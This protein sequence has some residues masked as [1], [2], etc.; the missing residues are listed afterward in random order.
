MTYKFKSNLYV[1]PVHIFLI[2]DTLII[3]GDMF[4]MTVYDVQPNVSGVSLPES[5]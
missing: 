3:Y 5:K 2:F 4:K 1:G